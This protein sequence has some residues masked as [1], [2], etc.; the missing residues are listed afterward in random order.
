MVKEPGLSAMPSQSTS[1]TIANQLRERIVNGYFAPG[2]QINETLVSNQLRVSRGPLREALQRLSQEGLLV[3]KRNRGVSVVELSIQDVDEI[4][5]VR[6]ILELSAAEII[7]AQS[8][9]RRQQ[10]SIQLTEI[11]T[12]LADTAAANDWDGVF[13]LDLEF[14]TTLVKESRNSRLLRAYTTL[15]TESLICM[16][17]LKQAYP[18][19][20]TLNHHLVMAELISTGSPSEIRAALHHHLSV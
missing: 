9:D 11:G 6:K 3:G 13:K 17:N 19:S 8:K 2:Q 18:A 14:H 1:I 15:A 10:V 20:S 5:S 7:A 4:Y 16:T 12:R